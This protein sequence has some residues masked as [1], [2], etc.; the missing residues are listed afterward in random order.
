MKSLVE[1]TKNSSQTGDLRISGRLD[2]KINY[3]LVFEHWKVNTEKFLT[4][5][6]KLLLC[7]DW[8][9]KLICFRSL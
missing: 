4:E 6:R 1:L 2:Y 5:Y 8:I 7:L 9:Q 3:T